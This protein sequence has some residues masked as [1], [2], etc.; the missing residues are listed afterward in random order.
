MPPRHVNIQDAKAH[1]SELIAAVEQGETVVICKRNVPVANLVATHRKP[2]LLG[3]RVLG[4]VW[5]SPDFDKP[6][7]ESELAEWERP[8]EP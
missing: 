2:R 7:T 6:L 5:I 3:Q 1:L 4:T 8:I